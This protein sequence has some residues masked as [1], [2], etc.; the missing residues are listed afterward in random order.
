MR[1]SGLITS[2][3]SYCRPN[4]PGEITNRY[5]SSRPEISASDA[6]GQA[7]KRSSSAR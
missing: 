6:P 4:A 1:E 2:M 5:C 7:S 3:H